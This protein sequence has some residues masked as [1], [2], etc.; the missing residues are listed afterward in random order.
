MEDL[1][2]SL[3][4][5]PKRMIINIPDE[6]HWIIKNKAHNKNMTMKRYVLQAVQMRIKQEESV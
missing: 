5:A 2:S 1:Q 6:V 3:R 4:K